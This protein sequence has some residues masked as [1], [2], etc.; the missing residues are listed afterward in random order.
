MVSGLFYVAEC[1][2]FPRYGE[3]REDILSTEEVSGIL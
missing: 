3:C 1:M 2:E